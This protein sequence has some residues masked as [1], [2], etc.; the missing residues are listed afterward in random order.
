MAERISGN[1]L[2]D[3]PQHCFRGG[4]LKESPLVRNRSE[5]NVIEKVIDNLSELVVRNQSARPYTWAYEQVSY[6]SP[7]VG[8]QLSLNSNRVRPCNEFLRKKRAKIN[9]SRSNQPRGH[10]NMV[11]SARQNMIHQVPF[12]VGWD[13]RCRAAG[14]SDLIAQENSKAIGVQ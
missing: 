14:N 10:S 12:S 5:D 3:T 11:P 1:T 2:G 6:T 7:A 4:S 13:R 8:F 9:L